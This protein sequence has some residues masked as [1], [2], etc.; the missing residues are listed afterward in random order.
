V[1]F[2]GASGLVYVVRLAL[3]ADKKI[4]GDTAN[5]GGDDSGGSGSNP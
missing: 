1:V 2:G 5:K 3:A 4:P